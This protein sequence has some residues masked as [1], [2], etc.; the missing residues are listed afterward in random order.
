MHLLL[1]DS[2]DGPNAQAVNDTL[3]AIL[4][5]AGLDPDDAV[6]AAHLLNVLRVSPGQDVRVGVL[7][8]PRGIARV[9]SAGPDA[10]TL[11]C[12]LDDEIP[13]R[14]SIDLLLALPRPKVMRRLWAQIAAL[15]VGQIILTNAEKV[16]RNYFDTHILAPETF[17]PLLIETHEV[18]KRLEEGL[19][20]EILGI[21][22][23]PGHV[24][25]KIENATVMG[26][27]EFAK[28]PRVAAA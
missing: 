10:V 15:G 1:A 8:G 6:R 27:D 25:Q 28:G 4:A 19:L 9:E 24:A 3:L 12:T 11:Q 14:P 26:V 20:R 16:E 23:V 18:V 22:V 13:P 2:L 5:D 21:L 17:R 7:D